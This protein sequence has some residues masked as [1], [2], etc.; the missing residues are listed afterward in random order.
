MPWRSMVWKETIDRVYPNNLF[1]P[2]IERRSLAYLASKGFNEANTL[3]G[4]AACRDEINHNPIDLFTRT[5][6]EH[7]ELSGL[8]GYPSAGITGFTAYSHHIPDGGNLFILYGPH[9]G[10]NDDG[11][12]GRIGREGMAVDTTACGALLAALGKIKG[13]D[14]QLGKE[15]PLDIEQGA[16]ERALA[17]HKDAILS[18]DN[19]VVAI[20]ETAFEVID[21]KLRKV[22][23]LSDF[24]G[25]IALL[26]GI[27]LNTSKIH[28]DYF[29][30]RRA[31]IIRVGENSSDSHSWMEI[32]DEGE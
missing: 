21:R 28:G 10:V 22:I 25:R 16:L 23:G 2:I 5:W 3:F 32:F 27:F 30:P 14:P 19:G 13:N 4:A 31:D 7:F 15:D 9:I 17:P 29:A 8:G 1:F 12:L 26:G 20:T 6:G 18:A 11:E 24:K